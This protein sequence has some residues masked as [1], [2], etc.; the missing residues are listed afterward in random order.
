[1]VPDDPKRL[2][3]QAGRC[4]R[5]AETVLDEHAQAGLR[6]LAEEYEARAAKLTREGS[7]QPVGSG[8]VLPNRM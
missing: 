7:G 8:P 4:R 6:N 3:A 1:M 2:I 5:L